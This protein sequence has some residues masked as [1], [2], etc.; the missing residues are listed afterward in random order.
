[1]RDI[2]IVEDGLHERERLAKLFAGAQFSVDSAESVSEAERLLAL[3]QYRLAI[4]DIGLGEKSGS[5]LFEQLRRSGVVPYIIILTGNP[6]AHLKQRFLEEGAQAYIVKASNSAANE[7]LLDTVRSLL[8]SGTVEKS[9]GIP[10]AE[11]I[12]LYVNG[13]SRDLF[14]DEELEFPACMHCGSRRYVVT[15]T[16]KTQLPPLVEGRVVC[17]ECLAEMDPEVG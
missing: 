16:H 7:A 13:E 6:S 14:L 9:T 15:F 4:I 12:R 8:G 10:L 1:M 17:A 5:H 3:D 11:F 2:L